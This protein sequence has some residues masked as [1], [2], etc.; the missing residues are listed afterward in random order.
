MYEGGRSLAL[1]TKVTYNGKI[2]RSL[3]QI[4]SHNTQVGI[5]GVAWQD[6][7]ERHIPKDALRRL[8]TVK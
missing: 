5:S 3:I 8:S 4:E 1:M 6:M 2:D 7:V